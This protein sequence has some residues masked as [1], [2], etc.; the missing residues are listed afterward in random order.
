MQAPMSGT[1]ARSAPPGWSVRWLS[2]NSGNASKRTK[3]CSCMCE[4]YT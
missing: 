4:E 1:T 3:K 2:R